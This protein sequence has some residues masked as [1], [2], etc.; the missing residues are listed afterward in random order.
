MKK[1][2]PGRRVLGRLLAMP[3]PPQQL[4]AVVAM[5]IT[6]VC[7]GTVTSFGDGL[8]DC[9]GRPELDHGVPK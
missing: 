6:Q 9:S 7:N 4:P 1:K 2:I 8:V 5:G 3:I